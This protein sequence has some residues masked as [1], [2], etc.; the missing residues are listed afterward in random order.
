QLNQVPLPLKIIPSEMTVSK[1][2]LPDVVGI[3]EWYGYRDNALVRRADA[4]HQ[5]IPA[6]AT[7]LL[8]NAATAKRWRVTSDE[9]IAVKQQD[10]VFEFRV[11]IDERVSDGLVILP[12]GFD[13]LVGFG[14]HFLE[15]VKAE[16]Q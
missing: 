15:M 2:S 1:S 12:A 14:M 8:M 13:Q 16:R 10:S 11:H 4:L 9:T 3:Y 5:T 7:G 6:G